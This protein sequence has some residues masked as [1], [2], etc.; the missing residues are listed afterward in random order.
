MGVVTMVDSYQQYLCSLIGMSCDKE[1]DAINIANAVCD[2][3]TSLHKPSFVE[4]TKKQ[5][6]TWQEQP[7]LEHYGVTD[8]IKECSYE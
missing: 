5:W 8:K 6:H 4:Q 7:M 2:V 3:A 1:C